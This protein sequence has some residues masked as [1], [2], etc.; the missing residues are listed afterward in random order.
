MAEEYEALCNLLEHYQLLHLSVG[1]VGGT[2][3]A[4]A[5]FKWYDNGQNT[6]TGKDDGMIILRGGIRGTVVVR[7]TAGQQVEYSVLYQGR[8]S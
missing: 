2:V 3:V 7:W 8:E 4:T 1:E 5:K 6:H